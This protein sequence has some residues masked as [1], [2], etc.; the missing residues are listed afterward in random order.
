MEP[1]L[2]QSQSQQLILSPQLR[3]YLKLLQ[4]PLLDLQLSIQDELT[5]NPVLE[6]APDTSAQEETEQEVEFDKLI[7]RINSLSEDTSER[8]RHESDF[9]HEDPETFDKKK[10]FKEAIITTKPTLFSYLE[11]QLNLLDLDEASLEI[12]SEIIGNISDDGYFVGSTD[13][14]AKTRNLESSDVEK[15]LSLIQTLEPPGVGGRNLSEVLLIQLKARKSGSIP[16]KIVTD[17]L[18]QLQRKQYDAIASTLA[19]DVSHVS[20]ACELIGRLEPKPGRIFYQD[21][22]NAVIPDILINRTESDS[23]VPE[24]QIEINNE[25]I[26]ELR[27]SAK[28]RQML[29]QKNLDAKTKAFLREKIQSA[30]LLIRA[31]SERKSTLRQIAEELVKIQTNFLES[32]FAHL[33]PLRL[34]DI[35]QKLNI[36]E[37][38]ISR[39]IQGKYVYCPQGTIPLKNF[40]SSSMT[41]EDG[42]QESQKSIIEKIRIMI[43]AEDKKKPLSDS[44]IMSLLKADGLD[45]ARRTVAK[46]RDRLKILPA[47]LR[48]QK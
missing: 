46:Y 7:N 3:Q 24:Y 44:K 21:E 42:A 27:I 12:A 37:S 40:F 43:D 6:E 1:R 4:L 28:Y 16:Q 11:W 48:K 45:I 18:P 10:R 8:L 22:S 39:A 9:S 41:M 47:H 26:P 14:I 15:I 29:K 17:F 32:G 36:H 31:I 34:K 5:Q 20:K 35:A 2:I 30:M 25:Y 19:I 33:K 23:E 38:T 13:E